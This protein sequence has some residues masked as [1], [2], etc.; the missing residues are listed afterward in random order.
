MASTPTRRA[1]SVIRHHFKN[2]NLNRFLCPQE[3]QILKLSQS[4]DQHKISKMA[5][6][7]HA[8]GDA[9]SK[10]GQEPPSGIQGKG[11]QDQPFDQGNQDEQAAGPG[12]EPPSGKQGPGTADKPYDGGNQPGLSSDHV[13]VSRESADTY[14]RKQPNC[15]EVAA[16]RLI[17]RYASPTVVCLHNCELRYSKSF[18]ISMTERERMDQR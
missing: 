1:A 13:I 9:Q 8:Q 18:C 14:N 6:T 10:S 15:G 11:T 2:N 3:S 5:D 7:A 12:I 4:T 17:A 16:V